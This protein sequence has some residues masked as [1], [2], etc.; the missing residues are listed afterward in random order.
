M[1]SELGL[2]I[3]VGVATSKS[4]AKIASDFDKPNGLKMVPPGSER[5]FL[6]PLA[7]GLLWGVGPKTVERLHADGIHTV[8]E[9]ASQPEEWFAL[10]F[11]KTGPRM[12]S[13]ALGDDE[14][15]VK[16]E[17]ETKS[18][19]A[20]T[21]LPHDTGDPEALRELVRRL[22]HNVARDLN[23]KALRGRTVKL[24]L[25]LADFTTFTRQK[26]V[27][28]PVESS[29]EIARAASALLDAELF[30]QR[31]FRL[32]GVGVSGFDD[33]RQEQQEVFQ[34]KLAGFE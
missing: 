1:K 22:S 24:K 23:R 6:A 5:D 29:D 26:T 2:T 3:S 16:V 4:V 13:L 20:E 19:S 9:L 15:E 7:V 33:Q 32:V 27:A 14:S 30:Q 11:G 10:R 8:G 28:E 21:T 31:L 34:L 25:R 18:I 12:R 17:R